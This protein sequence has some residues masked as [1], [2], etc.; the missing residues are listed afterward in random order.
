MER[1]IFDYVIPDKQTKHE[2]TAG[3]VLLK[4]LFSEECPEAKKQ[5]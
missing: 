2:V 4:D 3:A 1:D 5:H